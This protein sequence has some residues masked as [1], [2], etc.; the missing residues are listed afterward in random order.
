MFQLFE[1]VEKY[2]L[3]IAIFIGLFIVFRT[4]DY[5]YRRWYRAKRKCEGA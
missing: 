4:F 5:I 3:Y 1:F 2:N